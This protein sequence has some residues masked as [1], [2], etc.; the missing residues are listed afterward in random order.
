MDTACRTELRAMASNRNGSAPNVR[1][2]LDSRPIGDGHASPDS[3][4]P[5]AT[6]DFTDRTDEADQ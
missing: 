1:G 3:A 6:N 4:A 5:I 2:D